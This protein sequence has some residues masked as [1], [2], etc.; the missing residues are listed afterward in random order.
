MV[1]KP[2][3][4]GRGAETGSPRGRAPDCDEWPAREPGLDAEQLRQTG[5]GHRTLFAQRQDAPLI[6]RLQRRHRAP[7]DRT[8]AAELAVRRMTGRLQASRSD[9]KPHPLA[10]A[11][12]A[13]PLHLH[14]QRN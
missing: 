7:A 2:P 3:T 8:R 6:Y 12:V 5:I 10:Q 11:K 1:S 14:A 9:P 13:R 4:P